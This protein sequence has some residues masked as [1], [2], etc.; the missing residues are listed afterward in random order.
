MIMLLL[1]AKLAGDA[2]LSLL[3]L[4]ILA[5]LV[6]LDQRLCRWRRLRAEQD[7]SA[8]LRGWQPIL[9]PQEE[10]RYSRSR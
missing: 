5:A 1:V 7:V 3:V 9:P 2:W 8:S 6:Y 10:H 4:L